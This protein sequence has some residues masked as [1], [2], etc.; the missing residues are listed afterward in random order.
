MCHNF[1]N[2]LLLIAQHQKVNDIVVASLYCLCVGEGS[3][4]NSG[5]TTD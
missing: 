3:L 4:S 5:V 1:F 2:P